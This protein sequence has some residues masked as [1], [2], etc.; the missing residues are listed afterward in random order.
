MTFVLYGG[1]TAY[2]HAILLHGNSWKDTTYNRSER[3]REREREEEEETLE[4]RRSNGVD[5]RSL[6]ACMF[7]QNT[8][9]DRQD[10]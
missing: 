10:R 5:K 3:E 1:Y 2:M 6:Y 9:T 4:K 7:T 8:Y